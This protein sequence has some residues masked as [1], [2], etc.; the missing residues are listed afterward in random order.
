MKKKAASNEPVTEEKL[1]EVLNDYPTKKD[2]HKALENYPT[3]K[4]M[5]H[6]FDEL[7]RKFEERFVQFKSD[8]FTRFDEVM[9]ELAQ[10]R[11][12]RVFSDHDTKVLDEKVTDHENRLK[13]LETS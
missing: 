6:G 8:I 4:E 2:L 5:Y 13:K 7:D 1:K 3:K 11:E 12:D 9:G 10:H